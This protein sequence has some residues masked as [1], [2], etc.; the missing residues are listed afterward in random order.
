MWKQIKT[1]WPQITFLFG[2]IT[3]SVASFVDMKVTFTKLEGEIKVVNT[4]LTE[5]KEDI[6]YHR[7]AIN[8]LGERTGIVTA[9]ASEILIREERRIAGREILD[10]KNK[11]NEKPDNDDVEEVLSGSAGKNKK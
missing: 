8:K 1:N 3:A 11:V 2:L 4:Q 9:S 10:K 6:K 5:I 7:R